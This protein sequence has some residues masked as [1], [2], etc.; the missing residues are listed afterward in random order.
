MN[1]RRVFRFGVLCA[2]FLGMIVVSSLPAAAQEVKNEISVEA[3]AFVPQ[4][5][6]DDAGLRYD[7]TGSGG[8]LFGYRYNI[9]EWAGLDVNYGWARN[10][11]R[12]VTSTPILI[13]PA[14]AELAGARFNVHQPSIDFVAHTPTF[15]GLRPYVL[16]GFAG[17]IF[18]PVEEDV[19]QSILVSTGAGPRTITVTQHIPTK[20]RPAFLYGLGLDFSLVTRAAGTPGVGLRVGYRG[21]VHK[22]PDFSF[23]GFDSDA[24]THTAMPEVGVVFRF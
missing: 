17:F 21:F 10:S 8:L 7:P 13:I 3:T 11:Q 24:T 19:P 4:A 18:D 9:N 15:Y 12:F 5:K 1:K 6:T 22:V 20:W 23:A 14:G 2:L 16:A